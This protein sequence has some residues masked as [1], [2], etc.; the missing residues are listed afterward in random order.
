MYLL[1]KV[2]KSQTYGTEELFEDH[3]INESYLSF[4]STI[5]LLILLS[6]ILKDLNNIIFTLD[7]G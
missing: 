5:V 1:F 7:K 3:M 6:L 4:G 2:I